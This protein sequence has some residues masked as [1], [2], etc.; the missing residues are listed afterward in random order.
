MKRSQVKKE[1][2]SFAAS[3]A[4]SQMILKE[5]KP[6]AD[7]YLKFLSG[8]RLIKELDKLL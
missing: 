1:D 6:A 8:G 2:T 4:I 7:W 5:G 3:M